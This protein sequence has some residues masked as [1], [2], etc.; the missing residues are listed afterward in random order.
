MS[1]IANNEMGRWIWGTVTTC[2]VALTWL[3]NLNAAPMCYRERFQV[4]GE[5]ISDAATGL[6]WKKQP[7][8]GS[9]SWDNAKLRCAGLWRLPT[10]AELQ[11]IVDDAKS[12]PAIDSAFGTQTLGVFWS[13]STVAGNPS[14]AWGVD[15]TY[16]ESSGYAL[17]GPKQVRCVR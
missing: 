14:Q 12:N 1:R 3:P 15:F 7:E 17:S 8:T 11:S 4:N 2:A 16:G 6:V 9:F 5:E 10:V 13:S